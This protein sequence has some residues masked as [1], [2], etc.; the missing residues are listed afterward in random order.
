MTDSVPDDDLDPEVLAISTVHK[1]LKG[2]DAA[3]QERVIIYVAKKLNLELH[4]AAANSVRTQSESD[5]TDS[6]AAPIPASSSSTDDADGLEGISPVAKKW[7][8]R[9]GLKA[10][11]LSALFSLGVDEIDLVA[12]K[13]P[14]ANKKDRMR[15]VILMK[16]IAAYLSSGAARVTHEQIKEACLHYDAY[17]GGNFAAYIRAM[18]AEISGAKEGGYT[19]SARG[20][21]SA[22]ELLK[23]LTETGKGTSK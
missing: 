2:L 6:Q 8:S 21:T 9:N 11:Q 12:R 4:G 7:M 3:A 20:L 5:R 10:D 22:T 18:A 1:V 14:G 16:G 19:L 13:V 17:D 23:G 15:S